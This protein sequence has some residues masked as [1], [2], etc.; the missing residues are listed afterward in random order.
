MTARHYFIH[1][2]FLSDLGCLGNDQVWEAVDDAFYD[3]QQIT[4]SDGHLV[5]RADSNENGESLFVSG[6]LR[7]R[8]CF[9]MRHGFV[10]IGAAL[11]GQGVTRRIYVSSLRVISE[12]H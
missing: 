12:Y 9:C 2:V 11:P 10:E 3:P 1:G 5:I 4:T 6:M 8:S 7:P